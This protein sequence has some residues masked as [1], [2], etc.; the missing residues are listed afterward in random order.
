MYDNRANSQA[1]LHDIRTSVQCTVIV[2]EG[3]DDRQII[4][5]A[6]DAGR[7][8]REQLA[9]ALGVSVPSIGRLLREERQLKARERDAAFALIGVTKDIPEARRIPIIGLIAAGSWADAVQEPLGHT[10]TIKGGKNAFAL[11]IDGDSMDRIALP[12]TSVVIDPDDRALLDGKQY[13]VMNELGE[14]TFKTFRTDPAR[15]EPASNNPRHKTI[16][17]GEDG[18]SIIG[19]DVEAVTDL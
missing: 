15:F 16:T 3:M 4:K 19:R 10:W 12:G 13:A 5:A 11:R 6:W 8:T 14:A 1:L 2:Q 9:E 17:I 18:F 7:V